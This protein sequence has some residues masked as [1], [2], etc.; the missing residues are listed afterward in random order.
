[1]LSSPE[2]VEGNVAAQLLPL[3]GAISSAYRI[4]LSPDGMIEKARLML[5]EDVQSL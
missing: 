2:M 5:A 1:M 3:G 4:G